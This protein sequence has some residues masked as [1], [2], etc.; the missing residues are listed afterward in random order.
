[1]QNEKKCDFCG[2]EAEYDGK[3]KFGPWAYMCKICFTKNGIGLGLG[4]GQ[5]LKKEE[6]END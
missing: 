6:K 4:R 5:K 3:T 1:M 2:K